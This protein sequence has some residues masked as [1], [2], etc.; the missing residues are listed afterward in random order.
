M[1]KKSW[2]IKEFMEYREEDLPIMTKSAED[3]LEI[4]KH[5]G[6]A[7][8]VIIL[9]VLIGVVGPEGP[10]IEAYKVIAKI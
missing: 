1:I 4:F 6:I 10:A 2:T 9:T 8:I 5:L 3:S 7:A